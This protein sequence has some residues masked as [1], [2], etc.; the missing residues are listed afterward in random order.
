[1]GITPIAVLI[2]TLGCLVLPAA[3]Q[4][5]PSVFLYPDCGLN[6][7]SV[8]SRVMNGVTAQLGAAPFMAFLYY[9]SPPQIDCGGSIITDRFILTAAHCLNPNIQYTVRVGEYDTRSDIDC[10]ES[11]CMPPFEDYNIIYAVKHKN[12][13][14]HTLSNDIALLKVDRPI[15]FGANI[16]PICLPLNAGYVPDIR[17]Y[18]AFGWGKTAHGQYSEVLQSTD[19]YY[20]SPEYCYEQLPRT[21][22]MTQNMLCAGNPTSDSCNGDSGGPLVAKVNFDGVVRSLLIGLVS[23]GEPEC[24][25]PAVYT[26]VPNY[27]HWIINVMYNLVD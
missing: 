4:L 19:L 14:P 1:M 7:K 25:S 26:Y 27:V 8:S 16:Q 15:R 24:L 22:D 18:T 11:F 21:F 9:K 5:M 10:N 3:P 17:R 12:F 20:A 2:G 6:Y 13:T 23:F